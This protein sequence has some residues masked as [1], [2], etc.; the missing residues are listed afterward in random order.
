MNSHN[1]FGRA[2]PMNSNILCC[3]LSLRPGKEFWISICVTAASSVSDLMRGL[4]VWIKSDMCAHPWQKTQLT[5]EDACP[6]L[7]LNRI[8]YAPGAQVLEKSMIFDP[9][10]MMRPLVN[11]LALSLNPELC[12][13]KTT[14]PSVNPLSLS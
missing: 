13:Q 1:R 11:S 14:L 2:S 3:M 12:P 4:H 10:W 9:Y 8:V 5:T 7:F 6:K